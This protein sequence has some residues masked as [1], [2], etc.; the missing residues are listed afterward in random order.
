MYRIYT[1][2]WWSGFLWEGGPKELGNQREKE[3]C[4]HSVFLY[5]LNIEPLTCS[6]Y[7]LIIN[8]KIYVEKFRKM[9]TCEDDAV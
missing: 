2:N 3:I 9:G 5:I 4:F 7:F 6:T 8:L 1:R